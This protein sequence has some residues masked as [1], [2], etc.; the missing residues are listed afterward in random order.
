MR[1]TVTALDFIVT[2]DLQKEIETFLDD[3]S[4]KPIQIVIDG[5]VWVQGVAGLSGTGGVETLGLNIKKLSASFIVDSE[6]V[7]SY[8]KVPF[9]ANEVGL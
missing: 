2:E 5:R 8:D 4:G 7:T 9:T 1:N 3:P 6:R